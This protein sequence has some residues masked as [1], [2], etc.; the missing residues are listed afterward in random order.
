MQKSTMIFFLTATSVSEVLFIDNFEDDAIG[1][2]A[3]K[4]SIGHDG[5]DD[6]KVIQDPKR[7]NNQVFYHLRKGM[8]VKAPFMSLAKVKTGQITMFIGICYT[9]KLFIW[10]SFFDFPEVKLS[11][12]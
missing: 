12:C 11:I 10:V 8:M 4:R 6:S 9:P 2:P 3:T 7:K 1:K 5:K